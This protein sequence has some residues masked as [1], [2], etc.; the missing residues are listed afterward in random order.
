MT[1]ILATFWQ[2]MIGNDCNNLMC[3]YESFAH[4]L[5]T[6]GNK[7][8]LLNKALFSNTYFEPT[9]INKEYLVEKVKCY[10]PDLIIAFNNQVFD[11]LLENTNC[12]IL[13]FDADASYLFSSKE[14]I[15]KY[16]DRYYMVTHYDGWENS[17]SELGFSKNQICA[18]HMAT[19]L[20]NENKLQDKNISFIG[21]KFLGTLTPNLKNLI[22]NNGLNVY[23]MLMEFWQTKNF[24][25]EELMQKYCSGFEYNDFDIA[26]IFDYRN[27]V[28]SSI[29]DLGLKL[30]GV[31]WKIGE[32][33]NIALMSAF[34]ETPKFSIK[35][36]Q[37]IYNESKICLSISHPQTRGYAF[38]W[39][40]YDIMAT[41]GMLISSRSDLLNEFTKGI[42]KIPMYE[43]PYEARE[44]CIKYLKEDNLR[45]D[46]VAASNEYIE[47]FGRWKDNFEKIES[48]VGVKLINEKNLE[49][50]SFEIVQIDRN[51]I[52]EAEKKETK[53]KFNL[54]GKIKNIINGFS[55]ILMNLP[56][57]EFLYSKKIKEKIYHSINK[58]RG[59]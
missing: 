44:L 41:N 42:V 12:P 29:L 4:E 3:Y 22:N 38:P 49:N 43:S 45:K 16:I 58:Y 32:D 50:N 24:N 13:L 47:K 34:D 5:E 54:K 31:N 53:Y 18:I 19:S 7:V 20:K 27:Y 2:P 15:K 26:Y 37:D 51:F 35:H 6:F 33:N 46:I 14:Y 55:L 40:I 36:N 57:L 21:T 9:V 1:K 23:K 25:Y 48:L 30:Y 56:I 59:N 52:E 10:N 8:L 17:Y 28:L 11:G 39:R